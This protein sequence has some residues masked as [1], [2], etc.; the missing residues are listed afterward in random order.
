[1]P[2]TLAEG[3]R[4]LLEQM[5]EEKKVFLSAEWRDLVMLNYEVAPK[6]LNDYVPPGTILDSFDGRTY[7]SLVG[8]QFRRTK[9]FGSLSIPFHADFPE[10]NLRFYVRRKERDEDRRGVVFIA[11]IVPRRAVA[12]I[13]R[14]AYGE[15][16]FCAPMKQ[17]V[18]ASGISRTVEYQWRLNGAWCKL[19]GHALADPAPAEERSLEQFIT[20]HYWGYSVQ[21][22]GDSLEYQVSHKPWNVWTSRTA[23]FEGDASSLYGSELATILQRHPDSAFIADGSPVTVFTGKKIR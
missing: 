5:P 7:V 20:E 15:N 1:M 12:Q 3:V 6:L 19:F 8:L 13:A 2:D 17:C 18:S 9:L 16:Y 14:F 11:E 21:R 23:G 10:V 22:N 4:L